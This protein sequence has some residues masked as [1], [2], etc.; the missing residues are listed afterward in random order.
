[1]LPPS[2]WCVLEIDDHSQAND[3]AKSQ[4]KSSSGW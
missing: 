4:F 2:Q 3:N 1:M